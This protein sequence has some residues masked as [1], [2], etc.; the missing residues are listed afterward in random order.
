MLLL[1]E[2]NNPQWKTN[3][4]Q[5]QQTLSQLLSGLP[6]SIEHVGSTSIPG[7][8]AKPILDIDIILHQ[9]EF[10]TSVST[11][12]EQVGYRNKGEQGITERFAFAQTNAF[13]PATGS[14]KTWQEHH[15]YVCVSG[16]L[17]LKNHL[18]FRN[19]L[20][21]QTELASQYAQLKKQLATQPGMTRQHYNQRKTE[22]ILSVLALNGFTDE[23]LLEIKKANE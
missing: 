4:E 3:F 17:A 11:R 23:E 19:T 14:N 7:M 5:L 1:L 18:H 10:L 22:F 6:I 8:Y 16:S 21:Q 15:L 2:P 20:L 13:T 12:L 9:K